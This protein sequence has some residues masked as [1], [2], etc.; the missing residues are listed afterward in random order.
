MTLLMSAFLLHSGGPSYSQIG[1]LYPVDEAAR[2][3]SLFVLR[4]RLLEAVQQRDTAFIIGSLSLDIVNSFGGKGGIA[5]FKE[6][7]KPE[8]PGSKLWPT[9]AAVLGLGGSF[10]NEK[11]FAA[12]YTFS[13]FPDGMDAFE[14]GVIVGENVRVRQKARADSPV[15]TLLSFDIVEVTDWGSESREGW[16]RIK[17]ASGEQGYIARPYVRSPLDYRVV[18]EKRQGK[19][20]ITTFVAGD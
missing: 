19:W 10:R 17:L 4:A 16:V 3:A 14:H 13:Q 7:W 9:L 5:E 8:Q 20:L 15:V 2:D 6:Q 1:K 18:F 11:T 12:P